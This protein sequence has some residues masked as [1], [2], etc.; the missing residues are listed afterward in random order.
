MEHLIHAHI[1]LTDGKGNSIG[2]IHGKFESKKEAAAALRE[3]VK[4]RDSIARTAIKLGTP[5]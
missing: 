4:L 2:S 3:W 1:E 5:S